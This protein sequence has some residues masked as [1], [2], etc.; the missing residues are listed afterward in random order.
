MTVSLADPFAARPGAVGS[1]PQHYGTHVA[2]Q[3]ALAAG[4][5]VVLLADRGVITVA[6]PDRLTWLDS[7]MSQS[8]AKLQPGESAEALLLDPQGRI[9]H[10]MR[11]LDDGASL[12]RIEQPALPHPVIWQTT[13]LDEHGWRRRR[14][15]SS[16]N[17]ESGV[18]PAERLP[19]TSPEARGD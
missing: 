19:V 6:G 18:R 1:P 7:L 4:T 15:P 11:V 9:E 3:R 17:S 2:E 12:A 14:V 10:V 5:A 8:L 16:A 13:R